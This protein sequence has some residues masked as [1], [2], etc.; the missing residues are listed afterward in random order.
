MKFFAGIVTLRI[1]GCDADRFLNLCAEHEIRFWGH[2]RLSFDETELA[3]TV[4][5]YFRLPPIVRK[6]RCRFRITGKY[7]LPFYRKKFRPVLVLGVLLFSISAWVMGGFLLTVDISGADAALH[8]LARDAL[9]E[10]GVRPGVYKKSLDM[11]AIRNRIMA[12]HPEFIYFNVNFRGSH[13]DVSV[14]RRTPPP[15]FIER[16]GFANVVAREGG[17]IERITVY[18]G[19]PEVSPGDLVVAGQLLANGYMTGRSGTAVPTHARADVYARTW[20]TTTAQMPL[21]VRQITPT[22]GRFSKYTLLFGKKR[23]KI[24]QNGSIPQEECD[25]IIKKTQLSLFGK[26]T[27]PLA[28]EHETAQACRLD[29]GV[30]S[31]P[32]AVGCVTQ[33]LEESLVLSDTDRLL[34]M[35]FSAEEKYGTVQVEMIAECVKQIGVEQ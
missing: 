34:D 20:E 5:D 22:E 13:A 30:L 12:D 7:G 10:N 18:E 8:D 15:T 26:L 17:I 6:T 33:A 23:I 35:R 32:Y 4:R 2:R 11:D 27:L 9:A 16:S 14:R 1:T 3:V 29:D 21:T 19:T 24:F 25:R 31:L 28:L